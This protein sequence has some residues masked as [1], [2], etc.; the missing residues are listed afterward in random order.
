MS[1]RRG[2]TL[3]KALLTLGCLLAAHLAFGMIGYFIGGAYYRMGKYLRLGVS[4]GVPAFLFVVL[5]ILV[6]LLPA[7]AQKGIFGAITAAA[8]FLLLSPL[9]LGAG[10]LTVAAAFGVFAWL[11]IRRAPIKAA[12]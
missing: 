7:A 5:P 2:A 12:F 1:R 11:F 3:T 6:M 8:D 10:L 4:I 9:H